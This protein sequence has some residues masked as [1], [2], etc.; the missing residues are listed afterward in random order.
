MA[1]D[2]GEAEARPS[3]RKERAK[4]PARN[5]EAEERQPRQ[6]RHQNAQAERIQR[7][8]SKSQ[9]REDTTENALTAVAEPTSKVIYGLGGEMALQATTSKRAQQRLR[10]QMAKGVEEQKAHEEK[11][12]LAAIEKEEAKKKAAEEQKRAEAAERKERQR[13]KDKEKAEK[14]RAEAEAKKEKEELA[15]ATRASLQ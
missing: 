4:T 12:R 2:A 9:R 3:L 10:K 8:A 14:R 6:G 7:A 15:K 5:A 13:Q 1:Q 11:L